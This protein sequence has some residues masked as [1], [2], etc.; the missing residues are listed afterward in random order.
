MVEIQ[1]D[2]AGYDSVLIV[3]DTDWT[4][5]AFFLRVMCVLGFME[6]YES[7]DGEVSDEQVVNLQNTWNS[8]NC[9]DT[10]F[11]FLLD[12]VRGCKVMFNKEELSI[13]DD[14]TLLEIGLWGDVPVFV[15]KMPWYV[16]HQSLLA[17][18]LKKDEHEPWFPRTEEL[19]EHPSEEIQSRFSRMVTAGWE[20]AAWFLYTKVFWYSHTDDEWMKFLDGLEAD[21][22]YGG[23]W[24]YDILEAGRIHWV[25]RGDEDDE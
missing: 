1:I 9:R 20:R 15:S 25:T 12:L 18:G 16:A 8:K 22:P 7:V 3:A 5:S 10:L 11:C 6:G 2:R 17:E 21:G 23:D 4:V 14:R 24:Y 19:N 13:D